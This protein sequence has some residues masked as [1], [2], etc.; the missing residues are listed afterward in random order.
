MALGL[1]VSPILLLTG[2]EAFAGAVLTVNSTADAPD[3]DPG[4]GICDTGGTTSNSAPECTLRAAIQ[5]ANEPG[6]NQEI[7]FS[8]Q[9]EGDTVIRPGSPLPPVTR[10]LVMDAT[11]QPEFAGSPVVVIDGSDVRTGHGLEI[12]ASGSVISGFGIQGFEGAGIAVEGD[13]NTLTGNYLGV[14]R[15]GVAAA[16]NGHGIVVSGARNVIGG[17][18]PSDGNVIS[19]NRGAGVVVAGASRTEVTGNRIGLDAGGVSPVPNRGSGIEVT[20]GA[21]RATVGPGNSISGNIGDGVEIKPAAT[22]VEVVQNTV[23][24][25]ADGSAPVGNGQAGV[26]VGAD[27]VIVRLNQISGNGADGIRVDGGSAV[28]HGNLIGTGAGGTEAIPNAGDGVYIGSQAATAS[29]VGGP[30][31]G[32]GNVIAFNNGNGISLGGDPDIRVALVSNSIFGN[33]KLGID[34][35]GPKPGPTP[36]DPGDSDIGPNDILNFPEFTEIVDNGGSLEVHFNLDVP[37]GSY[38]VEFFANP[39]GAD[40]SKFGEG[41]SLVSSIDVRRTGADIEFVHTVPAASGET[42][43][44]TATRCANPSCAQLVFTSEFSRVMSVTTG[45]QAPAL[46][47]IPDRLVRE[48]SSISFTATASDPNPGD[49]LTFGLVGGPSGASI[50]PATG[51]FIWTPTEA[52]GPGSYTFG[53]SVADDGTPRLT[54]SRTVTIEVEEVNRAPV[55]VNP[56][57]QANEAGESV[58]LAIDAYDPDIPAGTLSFD[59]TGLPPGLAIDSDTGRI[60]GVVQSAS[61]RSVTVTVTDDGA[62]ALSGRTRF[63]WYTGSTNRPPRLGLIADRTVREQTRLSFTA[64]ASDPDGDSLTFRLVGGPSGSSID[65]DT[66]VFNWTPTESQGPGTYTL[67]IQV[68]DTGSPGLSDAEIFDVAVTEVNRSPFAVDDETTTAEDMPVA[69]DVLS[70]DRDLDVPADTL[71]ISSVSQPDHGEVS[72]VAG[73]ITYTPPPDFNGPARFDYTVGDGLA[74]AS[75]SVLVTVTA[76]NDAPVATLD[77]FRLD[78]YLPATLDVLANDFDPDDEPLT[79]AITSVP[80]S[81]AV[82]LEDNEIVYRPVNGWTGTA[83]FGYAVSDPDGET[84]QAT[85]EVVVGDDVLV[86]AQRLARA[87]GVDT[88][89]FESSPSGESSSP[90]LLDLDAIS[91]LAE[92]FLEAADALKVPFALLAL[93]VA[94]I[95]GLGQRSRLPALVYGSRR[96]HWAVARLPRQE[97]LLAVAEPGGEEVVYTYEPTATGIVSTGRPRRVEGI[98]WLPVETPRGNAWIRRHYLSEQVDLRAFADDPRPI[99]LVHALADSLG[100]GESIAGLVGGGG[101]VLALSGSPRHVSAEDLGEITSRP[102][103]RYRKGAGLPMAPGE[104]SAAVARPLLEAYET[105]PEVTA[106]LPH[107]RTAWIPAECWNLPYLALRGDGTVQ[108]WV[109]FFEYRDGKARIAGLGIDE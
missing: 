93:T 45:N 46:D 104:F 19:G 96:R 100:N 4:D 94:A 88:L 37:A 36:N 18:S 54:D 67:V 44:A 75:G 90:G 68:T 105:T 1:A 87:L 16:G 51:R 91:L 77:Q 58:D 70:N 35:P 63:T 6:P 13:R 108:P 42:L 10:R 22:R 53:V 11:T 86:G 65:S 69:I 21:D 62:P 79:V 92:S 66:G 50:D 78:S 64:T 56:G 74:G 33:G 83:R 9:A 60:T 8:I 20:G 23:G 59:A 107:S 30:R 80:S 72:V 84:S 43:T 102:R 26:A 12:R 98:D 95:N 81:G 2:S 34:L 61:P 17:L 73:S 99:E 40:P 55:V 103:H 57:D 38:R 101:V 29:E 85:V 76:V 52:Q 89:A 106:D 49:T 109:V 24:T 14:E 15:N 3:A 82:S 32:E 7:A 47:P 28:V 48:G 5:E 27:G 25:T 97:R 31:S 71:R 39:S 41:E